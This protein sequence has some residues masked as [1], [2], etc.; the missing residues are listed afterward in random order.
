VT[1]FQ[2]ITQLQIKGSLSFNI[3]MATAGVHL[4]SDSTFGGLVEVMRFDFWFEPS[5]VYS[6]NLWSRFGVDFEQVDEF[7]LIF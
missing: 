7:V 5:M 6:W 4:S 2:S 3:G 1:A